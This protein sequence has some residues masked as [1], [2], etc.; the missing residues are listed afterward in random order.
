MIHLIYLTWSIHSS[1]SSFFFSPVLFLSHPLALLLSSPS[2][3][4]PM[5]ESRTKKEPVAGIRMMYEIRTKTSRATIKTNKTTEMTVRLNLNLS[6]LLKFERTRMVRVLLDRT[7][8]KSS[9][10]ENQNT[11]TGPRIVW[12]DFGRL[13]FA[14]KNMNSLKNVKVLELAGLAPA[15]FAGK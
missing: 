7:E 1:L 13:L 4:V 3:T 2:A 14:Y 11:R 15:P 12:G 9:V 10:N 8:R 6:C 5:C